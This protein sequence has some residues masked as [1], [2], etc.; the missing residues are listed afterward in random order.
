MS[1]KIAVWSGMVLCVLL[2]ASAVCAMPQSGRVDGLFQLRWE[3][4]HAKG[5]RLY[6]TL[7]ND[8]EVFQPLKGT[9]YMEDDKGNSLGK[10]TFDVGVPAKKSIRAYGDLDKE[11][12]LSPTSSLRWVVR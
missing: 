1:R 3:N 5:N 8:G 11:G 2:F 6:I 4:P 7:I 12:E 10:A 9:V